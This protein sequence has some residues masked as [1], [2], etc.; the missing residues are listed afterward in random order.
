MKVTFLCSDEQHPVNEAL[1]EWCARHAAEHE[2]R[3]ARSVAE[4]EGGDILFLLSCTEI[5]GAPARALFGSTLVLHASAL[6]QGRGWSPHVWQVVEGASR[7][8]VTLLEAADAVDTGDIWAQAAFDVAPTDLWDDINRKL[9]ACEFGLVDF[10]LREFGR[11]TPRKQEGEGSRWRRRTPEDSRID[12][13]ASLASQFDLLRV[14]DPQRYPAFFELHGCR[15]KLT[16]EK[17]EP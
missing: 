6:P 13:N 14:C 7:I 2:L 16:I 10:A 3:I 8:T 15:Y 9:F 4:L 1:G 12:P 5:V 17:M 11:V